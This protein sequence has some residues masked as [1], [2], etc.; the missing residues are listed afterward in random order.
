[1]RDLNRKH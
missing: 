1:M